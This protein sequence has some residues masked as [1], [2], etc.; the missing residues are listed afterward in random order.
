MKIMRGRFFPICGETT[1]LIAVERIVFEEITEVCG[2]VQ[3]S[4]KQDIHRD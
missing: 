2:E 1:F 4:T 3:L